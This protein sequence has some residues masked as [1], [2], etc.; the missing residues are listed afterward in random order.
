MASWAAAAANNGIGGPQP[1]KVQ[2]LRRR[3]FL[4]SVQRRSLAG[5]VPSHA[6]FRHRIAVSLRLVMVVSV[7]IYP[8]LTFSLQLREPSVSFSGPRAQALLPIGTMII[9]ASAEALRRGYVHDWN[10]GL[11]TNMTDQRHDYRGY[12]RHQTPCRWMACDNYAPDRVQPWFGPQSDDPTD[13]NQ[14]RITRRLSLT[15]CPSSTLAC[16]GSGLS[17]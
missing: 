12:R 1:S 6:Q 4:G 15:H 16:F 10:C 3:D 2:P 9:P 13:C 11:V 5:R 14:I 7:Y 8:Q 17:D